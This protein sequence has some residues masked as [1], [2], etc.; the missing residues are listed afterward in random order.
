[1]NEVIRQ[2]AFEHRPVGLF[3]ELFMLEPFDGCPV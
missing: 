1:M 2:N 3:S